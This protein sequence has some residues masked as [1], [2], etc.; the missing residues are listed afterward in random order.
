[1]NFAGWNFARICLKF[2]PQKK[3]KKYFAGNPRQKKKCPT[4]NAMSSALLIMCKH[5]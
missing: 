5:G 3:I 1:M 4:C 2:P